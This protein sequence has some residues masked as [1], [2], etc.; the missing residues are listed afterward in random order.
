VRAPVDLADP[1]ERARVTSRLGELYAG[2]PVVLGPGTLADWSPW[3]AR[4]RALGCPVLVVATAR[5]AG[6]V[7]A[8]DAVVEVTP[9]P[10]VRLSDELRRHDRL[11]RSLPDAARAAIDRFDPERRGVW[12]A[13]AFVTSD[14][15]IDDRLVRGGRP[16]AYLALEDKCRADAAWEAA[17]IARSPSRVVDVGDADALARASAELAGPGGVVWSG[18]GLSGGGDRVR[19]VASPRDQ[20][21]ARADLVQ[22]CARVR[23]MPLLAGVPCS[24]H[25][26]VLPGGTAVLRPVEIRTEPDPAG[27]FVARGLR[28]TWDPPD[29]GRAEMR[30]AA[31]RVGDHL[32]AAHDYRGAFGVDGVLTADGF[33]P[34]E[35]NP[36][37][38]AGLQLLARAAPDLLALLQD[39]LLAGEDPGLRPEDVETLVP[40]MD[41]ERQALP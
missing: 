25:G 36:R 4:L 29:A 33:R 14:A 18:D 3:I 34:T 19:R 32:A 20:V 17:G 1:E 5:G 39:T 24:I 22:H 31:R 11:V 7:V 38:S 8:P 23:V 26:L 13:S 10:A 21:D 41:G 9:A 12:R 6:P 2:R 28:T 15:P 16:A 35:L 37:M 30:A 27:R 40:L